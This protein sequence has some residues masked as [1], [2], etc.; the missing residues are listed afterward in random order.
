LLPAAHAVTLTG[1]GGIGKS[2]LA[3]R[4]AHRLGRHFPD[5]VWMV[6]LAEV[7]NPDLLPHALAHVLRVY[8][9]P[10]FAIEDA[11]VAH[12]RARRLLLVLDNCEH[13]LGACGELVSA[14]VSRCERVRI[15]CTSR[16]RLGVA[17]EAIVVLSALEVPA[18][19]TQLSADGLADVEALRLLVDRAVAVAPD[20]ALTDENR[21]AASD[22]C[23]RLDGLPLAIEL[24]AVR[25]ASMSAE[26]LLERLDDRFRLL[27]TDRSPGSQRQQ[28]LR[29]TVEWSHELL[30]DEERI[31][32]RRLSVFAGGF[33]IDAAEGVCS[34]AGLDRDRV[35]DV[36]GSLVDKSILTMGRGGRRGRYRLLETMRLYGV[37]RLREAGEEFELRRRHA[38]WFAQLISPGD[39]PWWGT[40]EQVDVLDLLDVEWANVEAA[41]DFYAGS[42]PDAQTGLRMAAD[43]WL[44]WTVRGS[45]RIGRRHLETFL[46]LAPEASPTRATALWAFGFLAQA[47]G[48]H[49]VALAALEEAQRVSTETGGARELGY[50]LMGLGLVR[51]RLGQPELALES[52]AA[53]HETMLQVDDAMGR[54]FGLYFLATA[55]AG[56]GQVADARRLARE[57]LEASERARD[58]FARGILSTLLGIVEWRLDDV[59][60]AEARLKEA[61]RT[62]S[63]I[64]HRWGMATSL[65]GLAWV[66]ASTGRLERAS[67]LLGVSASIWQELAIELTPYWQPHHDGCE[68]EARAGLGEARYQACWDEGYALSRGQGVAAALEDTVPEE[69]HGPAL[70]ASEDASKLSARELEVARL[71]A[72]GLSNPAIAAALFVSVATVKTHVSHILGKLGLQ[73][74]VQIAAWV[75]DHDPGPAPPPD[76]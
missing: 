50:A 48:N 14:V 74:R 54:A 46:A 24:A 28:A 6:E 45:Y 47:T 2:R 18:A 37:E 56:S 66:A 64:G 22:I 68:E 21:G 29:A 31:L 57:G 49:D 39:R 30:S 65:E 20:F 12:L 34:G 59:Q 41:L 62:Q 5:G 36:L 53:S 67:L 33:G 9:R 75:A 40:P 35:L 15:L 71:V 13:L 17:G 4:A 60:A 23:R 7:D 8:E 51:L 19:A 26:D 63:R 11:L 72:D 44:H 73:S 52:L 42:A 32:W 43:L 38:A 76:R 25:L 61:V 3:L 10:D 58:T 27:A 69:R 16:Q 1:P 55:L 70:V